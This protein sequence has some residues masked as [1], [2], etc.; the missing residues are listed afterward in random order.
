MKL[1]VALHSGDV[2]LLREEAFA[3][4]LTSS[5]VRY[6]LYDE[7]DELAKMICTAA[8]AA[9]ATRPTYVVLR[10]VA[11]SKPELAAD[12]LARIADA[13]DANE[14]DDEARK[15]YGD[16]TRASTTSPDQIE[17]YS[18]RGGRRLLT[19]GDCLRAREELRRR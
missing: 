6:I 17:L 2:A 9:T 19:L 12:V 3:A 13:Y 11:E 14:L 15:F 16:N 10:I 4:E 7:D 5:E 8:D 18:G 1:N